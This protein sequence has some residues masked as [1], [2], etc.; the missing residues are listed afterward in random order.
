MPIG[1]LFSDGIEPGD[2][3]VCEADSSSNNRC[4]YVD[5]GSNASNPDGSFASP[6]NNFQQV[7]S[8]GFKG[9]DYLYVK[10]S[11]GAD[12]ALTIPSGIIGGSESNPTVIK[13]YRGSP[14]AVFNG[15]YSVPPI[16][17][18]GG[19]EAIVIQNI[20]VKNGNGINI[21]LGDNINNATVVGVLVHDAQIMAGWSSTGGLDFRLTGSLRNYTVCQSEFYNNGINSDLGNV[22]AGGINILS[23]MG[24]STG[25]SVIIKN[26]IIHDEINAIRHKHSGNIITNIFNNYIYSNRMGVRVASLET[27][28]HHNVFYD[29]RVAL[30]Y[31]NENVT[32]DREINFY[33]NT[34]VN[35]TALLDTGAENTSFRSIINLYNNI[36]STD[37]SYKT[38]I[39]GNYSSLTY[40]LDD[41]TSSYNIFNSTPSGFLI[42]D[43]VSTNYDNA[44]STLGDSTSKMT[45]PG[46]ENLDLNEVSLSDFLLSADSPARD[47]GKDGATIGALS[48]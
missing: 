26:N 17:I 15:E 30:V 36:Y 45:D 35:S 4:W 27:N 21:H 37:K 10:G 31:W 47:S 25:S 44:M 9:G 29:T 16:D 32:A 39:L 12:K 14:R 41:F 7:F 8:S 3:A 40:S 28:I 20:E 46:F 48:Q 13:S 22:N 1:L 6:Y 38:L 34:I 5:A 42:H 11:F 33:N 43:G 24:A 2:P 19:I 18:E 23:E